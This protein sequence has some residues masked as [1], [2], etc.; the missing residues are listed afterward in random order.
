MA[1]STKITNKPK[2]FNQLSPFLFS[3]KSQ[4]QPQVPLQVSLPIQ[5]YTSILIVY[6]KKTHD[7]QL[8][9]MTIERDII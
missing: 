9:F 8:N 3:H 4:T 2:Q 5:R 7:T 1:K 6:V